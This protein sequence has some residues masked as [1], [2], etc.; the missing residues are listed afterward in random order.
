[1][2]RVK[3]GPFR[4]AEKEAILRDLIVAGVRGPICITDKPLTEQE[5]V[6]FLDHSARAL[7]NSA[8][9]TKAVDQ[10]KRLN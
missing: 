6:E 2:K 8:V 9:Q 4:I 5:Y 10:T 3:T 7:A 1:M